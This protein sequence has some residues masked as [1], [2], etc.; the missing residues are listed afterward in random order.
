MVSAFPDGARPFPAGGSTTALPRKP[1]TMAAKTAGH[2]TG[3]SMLQVACCFLGFQLLGLNIAGFDLRSGD[4]HGAPRQVVHPEKGCAP[5]K[6]EQDFENGKHTP[7]GTLG[8]LVKIRVEPPES[9]QQ[10]ADCQRPK[11]HPGRSR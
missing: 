5:E 7:L 4:I 6:E 10:E 9:F 11:A 8:G 1:A 2:S 3:R